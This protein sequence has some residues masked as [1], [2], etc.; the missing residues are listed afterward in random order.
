MND[1]NTN[2]KELTCDCLDYQ[3]KRF[4]YL[5]NNPN[6]LCKHLISKINI[7]T[8][9]EDLKYFKEDI[10]FYKENEKGFNRHGTVMDMPDF[11]IKLLYNG[12]WTN[13]WINIYTI[14]GQNYGLFADNI[15]KC[16][17]WA[18]NK[19]PD[20]YK[21]IEIYFENFYTEIPLELQEEE[22]DLLINKIKEVVPKYKNKNLSIS[23]E[24]YIPDEDG[25]YYGILDEDYNKDTL[26]V[27][28]NCFIIKTYI[29]EDYRIDRDFD[30]AIKCK[31]KA[32]LKREAE[33]QI[34]LKIIEKLEEE[35]E[36][37]FEKKKLLVEEKGYLYKV[38]DI[39]YYELIK[40]KSP[41]EIDDIYYNRYLILKK[42]ITENYLTSQ[43]LI[44]KFNTEFNTAQFHKILKKMNYIK[45]EK[46]LNLDD[47]IIYGEGLNYG[48]N[49]AKETYYFNSKIPD[50]YTV[51]EW[52]ILNIKL[53]LEE[54][55]SNIRMTKPLWNIEKIELL[56]QD[57]KEFI[58]LENMKKLNYINDREKE[59]NDWLKYI[60]CPNCNSKNIHKK[61]KRKR[62]E[63]EIQR[64]QCMDCKRIFQKKIESINDNIDI[65]EKES[66]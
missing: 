28:N 25:V 8:L 13:D 24:N 48:L 18:K 3:L 60:S 66:F 40:D 58:E 45:K 56:L 5:T 33:R 62:K 57:I 49:L 30:F 38:K 4:S 59:R 63:F 53:K 14:D 9:S 50:W 26:T 37:R 22:I 31:K 55:N 2:T 11:G 36:I 35:K 64:Y 16:I 47:W 20:N 54:S 23:D 41:E 15:G 44:K 27:Q 43:E 39:Q 1:Y 17:L 52:D 10:T 32:E 34:N 19:K 61:D 65:K 12:Y 46:R 51:M 42:K 7:D 29:V 6:R 21:D